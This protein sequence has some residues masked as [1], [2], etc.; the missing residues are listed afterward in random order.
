MMSR[1]AADYDRFSE[2]PPLDGVDLYE[3]D[4]EEQMR[5]MDEADDWAD[6]HMD[7][8]REDE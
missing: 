7:E 5:R 8:R 2:G 4:E 6:R 3:D 1:Q